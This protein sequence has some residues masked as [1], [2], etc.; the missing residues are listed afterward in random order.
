MTT[1]LGSTLVGTAVAR[2]WET[3]GRRSK[4]SRPVAIF[5]ASST[6]M[7]AA[8]SF[9]PPVTKPLALTLTFVYVPAPTPELASVTDIP[10]FSLP[11]NVALPVAAPLRLIV[12]GDASFTAVAA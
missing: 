10:A 9:A 2:P 4:S 5:E 8:P 6:G 11:S 3:N 12:R 1:E 7:S